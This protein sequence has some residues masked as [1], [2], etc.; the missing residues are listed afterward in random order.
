MLSTEA[1]KTL[2]SLGNLTN[3]SEELREQLK[4]SKVQA[5]F[6]GN[7]YLL[8]GLN[9]LTTVTL[10][11]LSHCGRSTI[12]HLLSGKYGFEKTR[13]LTF[14]SIAQVLGVNVHTLLFIDL[15]QE[16]TQLLSKIEATPPPITKQNSP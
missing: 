7:V 6:A 5:T 11:K 10:A 14:A 16:F 9:Q 1:V 3:I 13:L 8:M 12:S 2:S 15:R 4:D